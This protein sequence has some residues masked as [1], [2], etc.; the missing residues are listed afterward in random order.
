MDKLSSFVAYL[1]SIVNYGDMHDKNYNM[2]KAILKYYH[3]LPYMTIRDLARHSYGTT[4]AI[5]RFL[6]TCGF[7]SYKDLKQQITESR[8]DRPTFNDVVTFADKSDLQ[9][10][11]EMYTERVKENLDYSFSL[12]DYDQ[13]DHICKHIC[14][15]PEIAIFGTPFATCIG[16]H[17]QKMMANQNKF[18]RIG[19]T[20]AKQDEIVKTIHRTSVVFIID[21]KGAF[22]INQRE[23]IDELV[24][25]ECYIVAFTQFELEE[26]KETC[27]EIVLCN[28]YD[29]DGEGRITMLYMLDVLL[30]FYSINYQ[31]FT[32]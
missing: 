30:M 5:T 22:F 8:S 28:K 15:S 3:E 26:M 1:L 10:I 16:L 29:D 25:K 6:K 21:M 11:F 18:V 17:F 19:V 7:E 31:M 13:I 2:A 4:T 12:L 14:L 24:K 27:R 23:V 20:D 32:S 9:P